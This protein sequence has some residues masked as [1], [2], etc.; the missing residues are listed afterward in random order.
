MSSLAPLDAGQILT[1]R[2][3]DCLNTLQLM[4]F[5]AVLNKNFL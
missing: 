5:T 1:V 3:L 2:E 4:K